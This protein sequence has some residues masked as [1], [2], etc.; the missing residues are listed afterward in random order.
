MSL[1]PWAHESGRVHEDESMTL[2]RHR[3]ILVCTLKANAP[4]DATRARAAIAA[5]RAAT[6]D[7]AYPYLFDLRGPNFAVAPCA[8]EVFR[9]ASA[10]TGVMAGAFLVPE[11][12]P[13]N[14]AA[15]VAE[16][17]IDATPMRVFT[18]TDAALRW[19]EDLT[20]R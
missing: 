2:L 15:L 4:I 6:A 12:D 13:Q 10:A 20:A 18:D 9:S 7:R 16:I 3:G 8:I 1:S 11:G 17:T 14:L 19:L 5:R